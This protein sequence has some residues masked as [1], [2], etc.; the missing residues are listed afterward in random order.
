MTIYLNPY[1]RMSNFREA[2]NRL[3]EDNIGEVAGEREMLLAMDIVA[4]EDAY[5]I[6]AFVP[7]LEADDLN[8][9]IINNTVTIRGEFTCEEKKDKQYLSCELP[10]GRF[11]RV[12]TLPTALYPSKAEA[13]IKNGVLTLHIPKAEAHRPKAIKVKVG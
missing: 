9:E 13:N 5:D 10:T 1:R 7:G 2:M 4:S 6:T 11:S 3:I 12:I 8:I